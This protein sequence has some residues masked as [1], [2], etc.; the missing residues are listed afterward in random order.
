MTFCRNRFRKGCYV[1]KTKV[2]EIILLT[3]SPF[4]LTILFNRNLSSK[5]THPS[6]PP[7]VTTNL[8]NK[9]SEIE[10]TITRVRPG[11]LAFY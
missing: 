2:N 7:F 10:S 5:P 3:R 9:K 6:L 1:P 8:C 4:S 11:V